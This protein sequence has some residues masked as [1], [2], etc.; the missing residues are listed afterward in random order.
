MSSE[1]AT[2]PGVG[3]VGPLLSARCTGCGKTSKKR[4]TEIVG[5]RSSGSFQHVCHS[6]HGVA[7]WNVLDVVEADAGGER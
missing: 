5:D 7:W 2:A 4:T 1:R 6:C 3:H